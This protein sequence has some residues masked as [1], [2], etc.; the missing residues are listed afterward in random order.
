LLLCGFVAL[1]AIGIRAGPAGAG[2]S[3]AAA[4]RLP[5]ANVVDPKGQIMQIIKM[6][7]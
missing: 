3:A 2:A 7:H 4:C 1:F 5:P 6:L